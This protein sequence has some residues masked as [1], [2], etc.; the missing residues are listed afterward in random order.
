M[1]TP[2]DILFGKYRVEGD[3]VGGGSFGSV[4]RVSE[5]GTNAKFALKLLH[6]K[7]GEAALAEAAHLRRLRHRNIVEFVT[8]ESD[9]R[10]LA[11]VI[12]VHG[13]RQP[14]RPAR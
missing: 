4:Y 3:E 7:A 14:G 2:G 12:G 5:V 9:D 13:R 6:G 10:H 11:F 1:I 8:Y